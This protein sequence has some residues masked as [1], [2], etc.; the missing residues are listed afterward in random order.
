LKASKNSLPVFKTAMASSVFPWES[1]ERL[2]ASSAEYGQSKEAILEAANTV[3]AVLVPC[4]L[5]V[6][7]IFPASTLKSSAGTRVPSLRISAW[8][9]AG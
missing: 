8:A 2:S 6:R 3:V 1:R 4:S 9:C 5:T 7:M